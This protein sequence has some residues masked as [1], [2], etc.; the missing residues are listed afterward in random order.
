M[1]N[2]RNVLWI[3]SDQLRWDYLSC[4]GHPTL[5][6][7]NLDRLASRGVRFDRAYVQSTICGPSRMS[8]YTGRYVRSHGATWNGFPLRVGEPT[9]GD[10]LRDIDIDCVLVGKTHMVPDTDGMHRLGI[11]PESVIGVHTAQCGFTPFERDDGMHPEGLPYDRNPPY[12]D[13]LRR[14]GMDG[15]N[16]WEEWANSAEGPD[17]E[18]LS[19]WLLKHAHLPARVPNEHSETPYLTRRG[20]DF[21]ESAGDRPWLCHLSYIKPH[22]PYLAPAP[23]HDMYGPG[24][25]LP[26]VRSNAERMTDHPVYRAWQ[27]QRVCRSFAR[28]EVRERVVPAYMGLVKQLDD[29]MGV[30]FDYLE[31]SG[32]MD[33]TMIVFTS[34]HGDNLG[35]HWI[36]EK[37]LFHDCTVRVPLIVYDPRAEADATRGTANDAL[38]E[39]IDLPPTF[40]DFFGGEAKPHILEGRS[41]DPLLHGTPTEWREYAISEYDYATRDS[42]LALDVDQANARLIMIFDGRWKY[43]HAEG[44][45]PMLFDLESDPDELVDLGA[46]PAHEAVRKRLHEA[47]FGWSRRHH[48]RITRT[49]EQVE[50]M[51]KAKEP[52]GVLIGF[53]DEDE[54]RAAGVASV[55]PP[56]D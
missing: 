7:P 38:V 28:D 6:T 29:Q 4:Y 12:D 15:D 51:T 34:D 16:P 23:Y 9:L 19:G 1:S 18:L 33:D 13:Y 24:D 55:H 54:I 5:Q 31:K 17:G 27:N 37:D 30:L 10:H 36:G 14:H 2:A 48:S 41:L 52:P 21:M 43:I 3:M 47:M 8:F 49:P 42:R 11:D 45:R 44:F 20:I 35:D 22:W 56:V 25:I 40:L 26:V 32:R 46:E 39:G 53:W 50:R